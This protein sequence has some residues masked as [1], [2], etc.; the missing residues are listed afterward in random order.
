MDREALIE[1]AIGK[2]LA[3]DGGAYRVIV[4]A[5]GLRVLA[6]CRARLGSEDEA[7]DAAQD[8]FVRAWTAIRGF[9]RGESFAAWL[10]AIAA[11][12][13]RSRFRFRGSESRKMA[14]VAAELAVLPQGDPGEEAEEALRFEELRTAVA[15]LP[16]DMRSAVE[17]YYFGGLSVGEA[18]TALGL[19][20]EAVKS[21]LF[22]A[23][24][25]LRTALE[26]VQPAKPS[27]G[28]LQ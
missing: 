25:K 23:R 24:K 22:R 11:N 12:H 6:F 4:D 16:A 26:S 9:R 13:V 2:I 3:G 14:A 1:A 15:E 20:E 8:V 21:R 17:L 5:Y 28:I 7:Q 10:F 18:A 19:G 27:G